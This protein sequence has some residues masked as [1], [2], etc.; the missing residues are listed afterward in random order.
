M[1]HLTTC[2]KQVYKQCFKK[3][4]IV[5]GTCAVEHHLIFHILFYFLR[6]NFKVEKVTKMIP[7]SRGP[8]HEN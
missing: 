6:I 5:Y 2:N 8:W 3:I 7:L 4:K 1:Y